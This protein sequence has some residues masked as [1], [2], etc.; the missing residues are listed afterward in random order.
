MK[1]DTCG[2]ENKQLKRLVLYEGY[3]ALNKKPLWNC[4]ECYEKKNNNRKV[5][6]T[7]D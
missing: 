6:G 5:D 2:K 3:D 4:E 1:C 7:V